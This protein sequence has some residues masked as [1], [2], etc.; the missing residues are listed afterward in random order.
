MN[1]QWDTA[2]E[3]LGLKDK[4]FFGGVEDCEFT[5]VQLTHLLEIGFVSLSYKFNQSPTVETFY[6]FG[7]RA[8]SYGATV[9][10]EGFLESKARDN[11][12]LVIDG[13]KVTNFSDSAEL[14]LDF[15]QTF[16]DADE[17][18]ANTGLLRAW[19]D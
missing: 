7:K 1:E 11:A 8:E 17:F 9:T 6:D 2:A 13:I 4:T 14:I 3:L 12:H 10:Y 18:T 15:S 16:H 5:V 19:Y